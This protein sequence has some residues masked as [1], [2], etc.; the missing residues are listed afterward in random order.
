V[1]A[2]RR[3]RDPF[4]WATGAA[5]E[6]SDA[7]SCFE[8]VAN[9]PIHLRPVSTECRLADAGTDEL[10][11]G[12]RRLLSAAHSATLTLAAGQTDPAAAL[13]LTDAAFDLIRPLLTDR[14]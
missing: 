6:C 9:W 8:E 1:R 2:A 11:A 7:A 4:S 13:L 14:P 3:I 5:C 12:G 10:L